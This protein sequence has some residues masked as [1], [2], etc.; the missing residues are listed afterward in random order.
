[1]TAVLVRDH[2]ALRQTPHRQA[3]ER[4]ELAATRIVDCMHAL[5]KAGDSLITVALRDS[6]DFLEWDHYPTGDVY[7]PIS[8]AQYYFHSHPPDDRV[9]PD[10][11]HFHTFVRL[12]GG[13]HGSDGASDPSAVSENKACHLIAISM[14]STGMPDRLFTTNRWVTGECWQPASQVIS[15]LDQFSIDLEHP[16]KPLNVW[17]TEMLVL[18]RPQIENLLFQRDITVGQWQNEYRDVDAFE[19]RELDVTSSMRISLHDQIEWLD[20]VLGEKA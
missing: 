7:D 15:M 8:R 18:F 17:L 3:L 1:M 20:R 19:N 14:T 4:M 11:G 2:A 13:E 12:P 9:D 6:G 5:H 10:Y 16:S